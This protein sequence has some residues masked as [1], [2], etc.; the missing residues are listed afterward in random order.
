MAYI[1]S[2]QLNRNYEQNITFPVV[3]LDSTIHIHI[4]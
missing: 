1:S 2:I 3:S 4:S